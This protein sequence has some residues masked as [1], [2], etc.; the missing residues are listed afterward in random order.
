M[1]LESHRMASSSLTKI[2]DGDEEDVIRSAKISTNEALDLLDKVRDFASACDSDDDLVMAVENAITMVEKLKLHNSK[3]I[4]VYIFDKCRA[5]EYK[6][7][8][9]Y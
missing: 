4:P 8:F 2:S 3:Q 7:R 5:Y 9:F 6:S 1:R